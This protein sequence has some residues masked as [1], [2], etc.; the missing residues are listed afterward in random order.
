MHFFRYWAFGTFLIT[1]IARKH[2]A[3]IPNNIINIVYSCFQVCLNDLFLEMKR[4]GYVIFHKDSHNVVMNGDGD[5]S[6]SAN[7][8]TNKATP[9]L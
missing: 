6:G 2:L 3:F 5:G 8:E 7:E 4:H 1:P 9:F